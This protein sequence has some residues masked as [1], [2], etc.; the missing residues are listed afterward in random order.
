MTPRILFPFWVE[1]AQLD[2]VATQ[3]V[4]GYDTTFEEV[5]VLS[6]PARTSQRQEKPS[7]FIPSQIMAPSWEALQQMNAG[8]IPLSVITLVWS[9]RTLRRLGFIVPDWVEAPAV[10]G[11]C[12]IRVNDRVVS[13]RDK[14]KKVVQAIRTPPGLYITEMRPIFGVAQQRDFF[15]VSLGDRQQG[16]TTQ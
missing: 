4:Q 3:N 11:E 8:N 1:V 7:V 14:C 16:Q 12:L 9:E 5:R 2:A 15:Y 6:T 10:A 13:I